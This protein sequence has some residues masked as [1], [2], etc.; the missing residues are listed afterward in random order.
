MTAEFAVVLPVVLV[1]LALVIGG[2]ALSAHRIALASAAAEVVRLEA[3]GEAEEA[4]RRLSQLGRG[5]DVERATEGS[6]LCISL[7]DRP[8]SGMLA[9]INVRTRACAAT[10]D[11]GDPP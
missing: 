3:R 8:G 2:I 6:L 10:S 11:V 7:S 9:G 4:K 1:V 5:V